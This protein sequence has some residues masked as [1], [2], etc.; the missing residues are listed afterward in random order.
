MNDGVG[1][2]SFEIS[3]NFVY[4]FATNQPGLF[5]YHC[6]KNTALHFEMGLFG[7][8]IVDAKKPDTAEAA[9]ISG[10]PYP[11][12]GPGYI[13]ALN[14]PTNRIKYDVEAIWV[15]DDID[16]RWHELHHDA[17]M[18]KCNKD[19]PIDP[20]N[21]T[22]DG[23]LNDFRPDVFVLSGEAKRIGDNSIF[24]AAAVHAKVGQTILIRYIDAAYSA[25]EIQ[26]GL[27]CTIVGQDGYAF[28]V[29]PFGQYS[30]PIEVPA[31]SP[32]RITP[33]MRGHAIVKAEKPGRYPCT[34]D[35]FHWISKVKMYTINTYIEIE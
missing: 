2:H 21:F 19:N 23:I 33:A 35:M 13:E 8:L 12:G 28:G 24:E 5:L 34:I 27:P 16:T 18:Q 15:P 17:F 26:L 31:F 9:A 25:E 29:G 22:K 3:G 4:Q 11:T 20:E 1:K 14:P 7:G 10:P 30:H 32:I 6:H